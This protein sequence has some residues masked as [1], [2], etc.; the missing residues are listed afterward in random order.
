MKRSAF[1]ALGLIWIASATAVRAQPP[2]TALALAPDGTSVVAGSQ[3]GLELLAWPALERVAW[4]PTELVNV[5]DVSFSPDGT[6]LAIA[7]GAPGERGEVELFE[8]PQRKRILH[9]AVG[10][11]VIYSVQWRPDSREL[12]VA[13]GQG[14]AAIVSAT[15]GD[16]VRQLEGHSRS[17]L[18]C[19]WLSKDVV[20]TAG[21][22]G[23]LSTWNAAAGESLREL[24]QHTA[25]IHDLAVQPV[26]EGTQSLVV[27]VGGDRTVRFW[28]PDIG[29]LVRFARLEAIPLAAVWSRDGA[30][31]HMACWDGRVRSVQAENAKVVHDVAAMDGV[32]YSIA[33]APDNS[34]LVGGERGELVQV[35]VVK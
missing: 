13:G 4:L 10:Q 24:T 14:Y 33:L 6:R 5:H 17:V 30:I 11:D 34:L 35:E 9:S 12:L 27:T 25:A 26:A 29:R 28:Q 7:G 20:L 21:A 22:E 2:I 3:Q 18:S 31:V 16:A 15:T 23:S 32:A 1:I 8:W 19:G